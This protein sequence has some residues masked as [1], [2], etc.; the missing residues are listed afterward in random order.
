MQNF[1]PINDIFNKERLKFNQDIIAII[2]MFNKIAEKNQL[3][4]SCKLQIG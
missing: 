2:E 4:P 1:L 3:A